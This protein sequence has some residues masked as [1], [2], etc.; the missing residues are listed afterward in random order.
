MI[1]FQDLPEIV[2]RN[3]VAL[4]GTVGWIITDSRFIG[5]ITALWVLVQM[6]KFCITWWREERERRG[7]RK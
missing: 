3:I 5:A 4:A 6:T 1:N 2:T 7:S